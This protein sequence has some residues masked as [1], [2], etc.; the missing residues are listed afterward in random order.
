MIY[1]SLDV[2]CKVALIELLSDELS[3]VELPEP[4]ERDGQSK[5]NFSEL[6]V[7]KFALN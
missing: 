3:D 6:E 4:V 5:T 7:R 1:F 2:Y